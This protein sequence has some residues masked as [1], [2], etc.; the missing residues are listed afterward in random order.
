MRTVI[1]PGTFDPITHGH[2]NLISRATDLFDH[3]VVAVASSAKKKP[4]FSLEE[5]IDLA[6]EVLK[7]LKNIEVIGFSILVADLAKEYQASAILRGLRVVSDFEYEFQLANMNRAI[8][9][10]FETIFLTPTDHLS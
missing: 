1:Y 4:L 2:S 6:K 3:V 8:N 7:P 5:R 10:D 9:G